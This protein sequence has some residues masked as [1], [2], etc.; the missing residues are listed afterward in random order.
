MAVEQG[1][2]TSI[3]LSLAVL[4]ETL[5]EAR[6]DM[7]SLFNGQKQFWTDSADEETSWGYSTYC[8]D[9]MRKS[10]LC[11]LEIRRME[12]IMPS[13][14]VL[15]YAS[16]M[17]HYRAKGER[18]KCTVDACFCRSREKSELRPI[19]MDRCE[20]CE[21]HAVPGGEKQLIEIVEKQHK[22]PMLRWTL[23]KLECVPND[24]KNDPKP[25]GI[26]SHAWE[27]G[28]VESG[29]NDKIND[30]KMHQCQL[31]AL[32]RIFNKLLGRRHPSED[33]LFW[34]DIP[35][36]PK[37]HDAKGAALN[38]MRDLYHQEDAVLV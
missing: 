32:Q 8:R 13:V 9:A 14:C 2:D 25:Y 6:P 38:Q 24:L 10:G 30:Q 35:C 26:L 20:D 33:V 5:Q 31:I 17:K 7:S 15:Y 23:G 11:L 27:D 34:V 36:T 22:I 12:A 28:I 4:G 29:R 3:T 1:L 19:H 18:S 37:Q 21:R 16:L